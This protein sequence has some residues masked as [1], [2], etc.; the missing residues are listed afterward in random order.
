MGI[1]LAT[2]NVCV[3]TPRRLIVKGSLSVPGFGT[4][5]VGLAHISLTSRLMALSFLRPR[6]EALVISLSD[7]A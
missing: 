2:A 4:P 5:N 7:G 6:M 1:T 3:W